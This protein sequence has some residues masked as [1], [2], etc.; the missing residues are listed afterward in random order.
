[1]SDL[2]LLLQASAAGFTIL[3]NVFIVYHVFKYPQHPVPRLGIITSAFGSIIWIF[4]AAMGSQ[5]FLLT[6]S[7]TNF[8]LQ[9]LSF[10]FRTIYYERKT[11]VNLNKVKFPIN[12][13][14][15]MK[16]SSDSLPSFPAHNSH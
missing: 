9:C 4:Y 5:Y 11:I 12:S 16:D 6:S 13:V 15:S 3:S 1:M 10:V 2:L 14:N 8:M 7:C